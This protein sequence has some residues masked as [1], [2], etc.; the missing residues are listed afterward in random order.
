MVAE[1]P[2]SIDEHEVTAPRNINQVANFQSAERKKI[3]RDDLYNLYELAHSQKFIKKIVSYPDVM[4]IMYSEQIWGK[5]RSL[6]NRDD[7]KEHI[8]FS[9]DTTFKLGDIYVSILIVRFEEMTS[10]P[11]IPL[12]FM[13]HERKTGDT[14]DLFFETAASE[15]RE[16]LSATNIYFATDEETTIVN[17]IQKVFSN[18]D[19]FRCWNH[20]LNNAKLKLKSLQITSNSEVDAYV[21]DLNNLFRMSRH[22][23]YLIKLNEIY[24]DKS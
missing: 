16:L 11:V 10:A 12:M 14:H 19:C 9:Y 17:A 20:L 7:I 5:V 2:T 18:I 23:D 1:A 8:C 22:T 4:C 13:L 3:S 15:F 6:L 24:S 21:R